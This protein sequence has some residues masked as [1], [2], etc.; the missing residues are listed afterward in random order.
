M[1][2]ASSHPPAATVAMAPAAPAATAP[3]EGRGA[4]HAAG[5]HPQESGAPPPPP[6]AAAVAAAV[7][8]DPGC[9]RG[10]AASGLVLQELHAL[11]IA[12]THHWRDLSG[13]A[14][15]PGR[16]NPPYFSQVQFIDQ[17]VSS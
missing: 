5:Q 3:A 15:R 1:Y 13:D 2:P 14:A 4:A 9:C 10:V 16:C 11:P 7:A 6:A 17:P 8:A 12:I